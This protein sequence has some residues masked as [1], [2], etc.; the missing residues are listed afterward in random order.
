MER[1]NFRYLWIGLGIL[2]L[3]ALFALPAMGWYGYGY[4]PRPFIGGWGWGFWGVGF[5]FRFL[6]W[7][8]ILFFIVNLFRR[9]RWYRRYDDEYR[10]PSELPS[11]EILRRRF[12]AG[13]IT[14]EQYEEMRQVLQP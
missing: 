11:D 13:E 4:G 7:G 1:T 3:L 9:R 8:A 2:A 6:I 10:E 5:F 14:R 12:A